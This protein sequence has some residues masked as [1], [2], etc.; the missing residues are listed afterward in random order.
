MALSIVWIIAIGVIAVVIIVFLAFIFT[1][2]GVSISSKPGCIPLFDLENGETH[3]FRP[4][5]LKESSLANQDRV[6]FAGAIFGIF[7]KE[8]TV[9]KVKLV[10]HPKTAKIMYGMMPYELAMKVLNTSFKLDY[11]EL[12]KA[13][14][15][16][17]D[18]EIKYRKEVAKTNQS[19]GKQVDRIVNH[20]ADLH[21]AQFGKPK[22][23]GSGGGPSGRGY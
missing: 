16:A 15:I 5:T 22:P 10:R 23:K 21:Q 12:E 18:F 4:A 20:L 6:K 11:L 13:K 2:F 1:M 17:K 7:G 14:M 8:Q 9:P 19:E 3:F